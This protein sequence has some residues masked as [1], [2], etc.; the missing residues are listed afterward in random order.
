MIELSR[1]EIKGKIIDFLKREGIDKNTDSSNAFQWIYIQNLAQAEKE[2]T[3]IN[4]QKEI[5]SRYFD[6][7]NELL[8]SG[9]IAFKNKDFFIITEKGKAFLDDQNYDL[10]DPD[11]YLSNFSTADPITLFYIKEA[12]YCFQYSLH[13][14]S[15]MCIGVASESLILNLGHQILAGSY[16]TNKLESELK[17]PIY[18]IS[19]I[20]AEID[21]ACKNVANYNNQYKIAIDTMEKYIR[22]CRN[23]YNH[24][25]NDAI[26]YTLNYIMLD[27]FRKYFKLIKELEQKIKQ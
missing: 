21:I 1:T 11:R 4:K 23:D 14:S 8:L 12:S 9:I 5:E 16:R 6:C 26:D 3:I 2:Y 10:L 19:Q 27:L 15:V 25:K 18:T 17:K 7:F 13:L 24:P 20:V 22:I